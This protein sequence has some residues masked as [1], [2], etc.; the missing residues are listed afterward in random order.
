MLYNIKIPQWIFS[1]LLDFI[2]IKI[3]PSPA[4]NSEQM[5]QMYAILKSKC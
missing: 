3:F 1:M 5:Q 2:K 4:C